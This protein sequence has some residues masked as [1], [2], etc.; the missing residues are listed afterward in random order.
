MG[1]WDELDKLK[2]R[3][4]REIADRAAKAAVDKSKEAAASAFESAKKKIGDALFGEEEPAPSSQLSKDERK[5]KE[6]ETGRKLREAAAR[7]AD[8]VTTEKTRAE[9]EAREAE[10]REARARASAEAERQI[11]DELAALKK[12]IG[13]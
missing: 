1:V 13:K 2:K 4:Q 12:K 8:R 11:D 6:D 3:A 7:Q 9:R 10:A 5:S